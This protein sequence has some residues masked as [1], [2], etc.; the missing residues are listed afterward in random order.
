MA[1]EQL[2][3]PLSELARFAAT[4]GWPALRLLQHRWLDGDAPVLTTWY[5]SGE[6][7]GFRSDY[8][9]QIN[10][11]PAGQELSYVGAIYAMRYR[12]CSGWHPLT[13]YAT[14]EERA[15][16]A[17]RVDAWLH[18]RWFETLAM[19]REFRRLHPECADYTWLRIRKQGP[20]YPQDQ[21]AMA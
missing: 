9:F 17:L 13:L 3:K 7:G 15:V 21:A 18:R 11:A 19:R 20:P 1:K 14:A 10:E 4:L 6:S 8:F 16:E 12:I 5:E 2:P